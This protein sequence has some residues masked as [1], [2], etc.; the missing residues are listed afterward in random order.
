MGRGM[1]GAG[2]EGAAPQAPQWHGGCERGAQVV[3]L[4]HNPAGRTTFGEEEEKQALRGQ[5]TRGADVPGPS[6]LQW[7]SC[8]KEFAQFGDQPG[9]GWRGLLGLWKMFWSIWGHSIH[10][11]S[12][13]Q[14]D[15]EGRT[16]YTGKFS[17]C[18]THH[19]GFLLMPSRSGLLI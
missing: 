16:D 11:F 18:K 10:W 13:W 15:S 5:Q 2:E 17:C 19:R 12:G 3:W 7:L 14:D 1:Y 8:Q 6:V 4:W 9:E